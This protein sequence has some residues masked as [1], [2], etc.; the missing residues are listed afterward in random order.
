MGAPLFLKALFNV[1]IWTKLWIFQ[2]YHKSW[3]KPPGLKCVW[4]QQV[5][6]YVKKWKTQ[7]VLPLII[8]MTKTMWKNEKMENTMCSSSE[9]FRFSMSPDVNFRVWNA[10]EFNKSKILF[11]ECSRCSLLHIQKICVKRYMKC[12]YFSLKLNEK[13][14]KRCERQ[15]PLYT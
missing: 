5:E 12:L 15:P 13:F 10:S 3:H 1:E 2:V 7:C 6:D 14:K 4:I 11:E 8:L 9:T